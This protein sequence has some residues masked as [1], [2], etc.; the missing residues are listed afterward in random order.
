MNPSFRSFFKISTTVALV[1]SGVPVQAEIKPNG[2]FSE[3]AVLQRGIRVPVWGSAREGEPVT[4]KFQGQEVRTIAKDGGWR[5]QLEPLNAGGPFTLTLIGDNTISFS[6]VWVGEV[7]LS[8][9]QSN[10]S[11]PLAGAANGKEAIAASVDPQLRLFS[12]P[13]AATDHPLTSVEGGWKTS[14]PATV[15]KFSAVAYFLGRDLRRAL[16]VPIGL[17][18]ASVGGTPAQAWTPLNALKSDPALKDILVRYDESLKTYDPAKAAAAYENEVKKYP[19][20]VAKAKSE[21]KQ[22]PRKPLK[23]ADPSR[24]NN[25]PGGLYN[26]MISPLESYAMAGVIWYQGEANAGKAAEYQ[27]LFPAMIGSWRSAWK[28]GDFPF[29]FVQ[30]APNQQMTPE[31]R[32][33]Q[34][35]SWQ[36]VKNTAMVVTTDVGDRMNIHPTRKAPVGARLALAARALAYGEKIEFSGPVFS[37]MTIRGKRAELDF[38][39]VG[40]GLLARGGDLRGFTIAGEDGVFVP[41][42]ATIDGNKVIVSSSTVANPSAVRYGWDKV[43]D[44]NLFNAEGLPATPFRTDGGAAK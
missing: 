35:L 41:A 42:V 18:D 32:E 16:K 31:I 24:R 40:G 13:H 22:A 17:I 28:Q 7:W 12:V 6:D 44:V 21:G 23:L 37:A 39:H 10:M 4:V 19:D 36:R 8:S 3:G 29:L 38:T 34:L 25:R 30:I 20:R 1:I 9:G 15:A 26:A 14:S 27:K 43:P 2:L 11:F 5:I 33:A